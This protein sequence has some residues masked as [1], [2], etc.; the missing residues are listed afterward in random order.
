VLLRKRALQGPL[1]AQEPQAIAQVVGWQV[2]PRP[3]SSR[4]LVAQGGRIAWL[5]SARRHHPTV[6]HST[7]GWTGR[8]YQ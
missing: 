6:P 4:R 2:A 5:P 8:R 1:N 7:D 3:W